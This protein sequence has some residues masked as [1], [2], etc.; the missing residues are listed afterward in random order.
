MT[1]NDYNSDSYSR[2]RLYSI[3][4]NMKSRC[5][6]RSKGKGFE[7]YGGRGI[8][9]C[10]EWK[11]SFKAFESWSLLNG[12]D[13][14]LELDRIG[15]DDSYS[16]ETCRYVSHKLNN[17]TRRNC[18]MVFYKGE[19]KC[20]AAWAEQLNINYNTLRSRFRL[21]WSVERAFEE[22]VRNNEKKI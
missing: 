15:V 20:I 9:V 13:D 6:C 5:Y 2:K 17:R 4:K 11:E 19:K 21:G 18:V 14:H 1:V 8:G 10:D 22:E 3:W 7:R 16:P 12:Y